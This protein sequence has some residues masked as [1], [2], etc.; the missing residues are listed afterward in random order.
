MATALL[1]P[2]VL[3]RPLQSFCWPRHWSER[4][5]LLERQHDR[6]EAQLAGMIERH[7]D[8]RVELEPDEAQ[9]EWRDGARLLRQL[10]L[11]L[12]LE[13]RWLAEARVLCGGHRVSHRQAAERAIT[14]FREGGHRRLA[15]LQWLLEIQVWFDH[16]RLGADAI[17]YARA[18]GTSG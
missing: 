2:R 14:G 17:A 10:R 4:R 18:Q 8:G 11:H 13:E 15:R 7:G 1:T 12:R 3:D 9:R 6:L 16:H 5:P